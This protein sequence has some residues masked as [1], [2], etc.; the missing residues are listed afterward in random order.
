MGLDDRR[1]ADRGTQYLPSRGRSRHPSFTLASPD[2]HVPELAATAHTPLWGCWFTGAVATPT[3][4]RL[5]ARRGSRRAQK[6][7][8]SLC[9]HGIPLCCQNPTRP[10]KT[11][12]S[13][14][15]LW[16]HFAESLKPTAAASMVDSDL[17]SPPPGPPGPAP[18]LPSPRL[19]H[20]AASPFSLTSF[21]TTTMRS[22]WCSLVSLPLPLPPA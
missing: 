1:A 16:G 7:P 9:L 8:P 15:S 11:N 18:G 2:A 3:R 10:M 4:R 12:I 13:P 14:P 17:A 21:T 5:I 19:S 20:P 6:C 22:V